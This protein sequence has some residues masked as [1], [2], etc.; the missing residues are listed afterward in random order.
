MNHEV[1]NL[2]NPQVVAETFDSIR[3]SIAS[4]GENSL[5]VVRRDQEARNDQLPHLQAGA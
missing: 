4:P 1:M 5:L 2:F 3:I